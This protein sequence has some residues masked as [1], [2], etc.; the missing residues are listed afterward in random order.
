MSFQFHSPDC[1]VRCKGKPR[2]QDNCYNTSP[3]EKEIRTEMRLHIMRPNMEHDEGERVQ[4]R[5]GEEGVSYPSVE[6]LKLLVRDTG[7][8]CDPIRL[9]CCGT[10]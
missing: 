5:Q 9:G 8:Q 6:H 10:I 2:L 4:E 1:A 3:V 7:E